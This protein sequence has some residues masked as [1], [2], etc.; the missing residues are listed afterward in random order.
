MTTP[1]NQFSL[2]AANLFFLFM[3]AAL[4]AGCSPRKSDAAQ[5]RKPQPQSQI[6]LPTVYGVHAVE[7]GKCK[8]LDNLRDSGRVGNLRPGAE[9]IVFHKLVA[10][11]RMSELHVNK[12]RLAPLPEAPKETVEFS[13]S[14]SQPAQPV[15]PAEPAELSIPFEP[16]SEFVGRSG[17]TVEFISDTMP[18]AGQPEMIRLVTRKA[19]SPGLYAL[20]VGRDEFQFYV[21]RETVEKDFETAISQA[22]DKKRWAD[23]WRLVKGAGG[24]NLLN[25]E[26]QLGNLFSSMLD[27]AVADARASLAQGRRDEAMA[28]ARQLLSIGREA[29]Q[30]PQYMV[31]LVTSNLPDAVQKAQAVMAE[32]AFEVRGDSTIVDRATGLM[33]QADGTHPYNIA[34]AD[35]YVTGLRLGGHDDW[36]LPS[37]DELKALHRRLAEIG[38]GKFVMLAPFTWGEGRV[39]WGQKQPPYYYT[40][41]L[42]ELVAATADGMAG[43]RDTAGGYVRA[44][45][46]TK[47]DP[48]AMIGGQPAIAWAYDRGY[49]R[50]F[51]ELVK[52]GADPAQCQREDSATG[53]APRQIGSVV[54]GGR[55]IRIVADTDQPTDWVTFPWKS[56]FQIHLDG[57]VQG[58]NP[59]GDSWIDAPDSHLSLD[60]FYRPGEKYTMRFRSLLPGKKTYLL[61]VPVR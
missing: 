25:F 10:M 23:G 30:S 47:L 6:E 54:Y 50:L 53:D 18:V 34:E 57:R 13:L 51:E 8:L 2:R 22:T 27:K 37:L 24:R 36:R 1:K 14:P 28:T 52:A 32:I 38:P 59:R 56:S 21:A 9:F 49:V 3:I 35:A 11:G 4:A 12:I 42:K 17:E 43:R 31:V 19:L 48:K 16:D 26:N 29:G 45:R 5:P 33:W 39:A 15:K 61:A 60:R 20:F 44:V 7:D 55:S 41:D 40:S 58:E 46:W